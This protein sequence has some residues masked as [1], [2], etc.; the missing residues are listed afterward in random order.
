MRIPRIYLDHNLETPDKQNSQEIELPKELSLYL[1]SV[2][3]RKDGNFIKI[4]NNRLDT[5]NYYGE[6]TAEITNIKKNNITVK[7]LDY[8]AIS[9]PSTKIIELAQCISK[10]QHF[11]IALQKSVELGVNIITPIVSARSEENI[12]N[13]NIDN[14]LERWQ[15]III[16]ACEQSGRVDVPKL[17]Q[18]IEIDNWVD[19]INLHPD[20][21]KLLIT[22][23]TK[24]NKTLHSLD[25]NNKDIDNI[26]IIIGP[27]GGFTES[28]VS[29]LEN[30]DFNLVKLGN[31]IMRTE[32]ASIVSLAI[33]QY[34]LHNL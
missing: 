19:L 21:N 2:L 13:K 3:R 34:L 6:Y 30:S 17:N 33:V 12:N 9:P 16:G 15:K 5:S 25:F 10:P 20:N 27:E 28:E 24:T 8:T 26:K 1:K 23:C 31:R 18:P 29:L 7:I 14:K 11:E 32:T 22:L 4:F